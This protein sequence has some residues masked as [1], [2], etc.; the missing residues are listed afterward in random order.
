MDICHP[1]LDD[2]LSDIRELFLDVQRKSLVR[3]E[4]E[5]LNNIEA[6][7]VPG[8]H[9]YNNPAGFAMDP[10]AYYVCYK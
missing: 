3:L 7:T 5:G 8:G 6:I 2:L 1:L 10:Y 4:F 9:Y